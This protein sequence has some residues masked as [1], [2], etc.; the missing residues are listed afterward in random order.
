MIPG[1]RTVYFTWQWRVHR[2]QVQWC[3]PKVN[4]FSGSYVVF[5]GNEHLQP[6]DAFS[7]LLV[8]PKC[9]CG[10]GAP[11]Q[12]PLGE[13]TALPIPSSWTGGRTVFSLW[14][15]GLEFRPFGP[16]ECSPRQEVPGYAA[17]RCCSMN[18]SGLKLH[19]ITDIAAEMSVFTFIIKHLRNGFILHVTTDLQLWVAHLSRS[20]SAGRRRMVVVFWATLYVHR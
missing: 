13:L 18:S 12:T 17:I 2:V 6:L 14:A 5:A 7:G 16:Q 4:D 20:R 10:S 3:I 8:R 19:C 15:F 1:V 9:I 11:P